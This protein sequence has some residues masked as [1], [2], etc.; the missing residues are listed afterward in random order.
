MP[1]FTTP[2]PISASIEVTVGDIRVTAGE[3]TDTV[4]EVRPSDPRQDQ[5]VRAAQQTRIDFTAGRLVVTTSRLRGLG[6]FGKVGSVDIDVE[7]PSDSDLQVDAQIA[8]VRCA[9][10]LRDC[11]VKTATGD[12]QLGSGARLELTTGSGG[13]AAEEAASVDVTTGSGKVR[14]GLVHGAAVVKN[15]NGSTWLGEVVGDARVRSANGDI[16]VE[17]AHTGLTATTANGDLYV[18]SVDAG[19]VSLKTSCGRV[20]VGLPAGTAARLDVHT[21]FGSLRNLLHSVAGPEPTDRTVELHARTDYGDIVVR[22][23]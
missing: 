2:Q 8:A 17:H 5:D 3:R 12:I 15:S 22:R 23:A 21:S 10:R 1:T 11:R 18:G 6:L 7:L 19:S 13:V 16:T 9:G 20:E 4:V 14:L